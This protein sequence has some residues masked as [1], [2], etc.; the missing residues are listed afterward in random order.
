MKKLILLSGLMVMLAGCG[1]DATEPE[2]EPDASDDTALVDDSEAEDIEDVEVDT[3]TETPAED[4][5][6]D[7]EDS[8][9]AA[10]VDPN[11]TGSDTEAAMP[12]EIYTNTSYQ[13]PVQVGDTTQF[14]FEYTD[15]AEAADGPAPSY[16]GIAQVRVTDVIRGGDEGGDA[17]LDARYGAGAIGEPFTGF[18]WVSLELDL[19][20]S[21]FESRSASYVFRQL[22]YA[23]LPS[24]DEL[25]IGYT[26]FEND[27]QNRYL[28]LGDTVTETLL[29]QVPMDTPFV[30][31]F[32]EMGALDTVYVHIP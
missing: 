9:D 4:D 15:V 28:R 30:L 29:M 31:R 11:A 6:E 7:T 20:L 17:A 5:A 25:D 14:T 8:G 22:P 1:G 26:Y 16:A 2:D 12:D 27:I 21:K 13:Y 19:H 23:I 24:G 18:E 3:E 32:G 10:L